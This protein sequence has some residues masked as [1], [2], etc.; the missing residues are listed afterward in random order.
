MTKQ[1]F[2]DKHCIYISDRNRAEAATVITTGCVPSGGLTITQSSTR[3]P[4]L[5]F[6]PRNVIGLPPRG[7]PESAAE[8]DIDT[9][10]SDAL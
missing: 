10:T 2:V 9:D 1:E 8:L 7:T 3:T 4:P 6:A 5:L